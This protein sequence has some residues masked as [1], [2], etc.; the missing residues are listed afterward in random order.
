M[1]ILKKWMVFGL[2]AFAFVAVLPGCSKEGGYSTPEKA[3]A[4]PSAVQAASDKSMASA[5]LKIAA[6]GPQSTTAGAVFNAQPD[7]NAALWV[8]VN[9]SLDGSDSVVTM[10]GTALHS[11]ISGELITASVPASFYA[12]AGVHAL[13]I[14]MKKGTTSTQSN[15]VDF[16]VQ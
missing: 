12:K 1:V 9:Q 15:D 8:K 4:T 7:G 6:W 10:D 13:H 3:Q 5:D 14:T 11:A 2:A 16:V